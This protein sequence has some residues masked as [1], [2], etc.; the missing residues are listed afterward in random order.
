MSQIQIE[1]KKSNHLR[2]YAI[3]MFV[4]V[5]IG[6]ATYNGVSYWMQEN[7]VSLLNL[8]RMPQITDS[9]QIPNTTNMSA[10]VKDNY[11]YMGHQFDLV[12]IPETILSQVFEF[13]TNLSINTT[14]MFSQTL[15][16]NEVL[17]V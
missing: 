15:T 1:P 3:V 4:L 6:C 14:Y 10:L 7:N 17:N 9:E 8:N 13:K 2:N 11:D 16:I 5:S 12:N